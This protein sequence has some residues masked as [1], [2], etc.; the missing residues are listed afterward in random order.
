MSSSIEERIVSMKFNNAQFES[1]VSETMSSLKELNRTIES[2]EKSKGFNGLADS[3]RKVSSELTAMKVI[4]ITALANITNQAVNAG[5]RIVSALTLDPLKSGF[6]EYQEQ[7]DS[8]MVIMSNTG[9][10]LNVVTEALDE[11]NVYA[12]KTVYSFSQMTTAIGKFAA[13]GVNLDNSVA[14]IKGLSNAA[15]LVGANNSQLY[16]AYYNLAQSLQMGY[17]QTIDYNSLSNSTIMNKK[18][19]DIMVETAIEMGKFTKESEIAKEAY[20]DFKGSL[21]KK[22]LTSDIILK[23]LEKYSSVETTIGKEATAAATEVKSFKQLMDTLME[24]IGTGWADT[25]KVLVGD[26]NEAKSLFTGISQALEVFTSSSSKARLDFVKTWKALGGREALIKSFYSGLVSIQSILSPIKTA[27]KDVFPPI[28]AK[29]VANTTNKFLQLVRSMRLTADESKGLYNS[30]TLLLLPAKVLYNVVTTS[31][32][33]IAIL[34]N[35]IVNLGR[36]FL[37]T[38]SS[39]EKIQNGLKAIFGDER[40]ERLLVAFDKIVSKVTYTIGEFKR[41]INELKTEINETGILKKFFDSFTNGADG[42]QNGILD[43]FVEF[44]EWLADL[45]FKLQMPDISSGIID[46]LN[47]VYNTG[48]KTG[49]VLQALGKGFDGLTTAIGKVVT[50]TNLLNV[51]FG[52]LLVKGMYGVTQGIAGIGLGIFGVGKAIKEGAEVV[53]SVG[54]SLKGFAFKEFSEGIKNVGQAIGI[55]A[56]SMLLLS[57][58][59]SGALQ[60]ATLALTAMG[61]VLLLFAGSIGKFAESLKFFK[62]IQVKLIMDEAGNAI[63]KLGVAVL[64]L[65]SSMKMTGS[66]N[67]DEWTNG[68]I[69]VAGALGGLALTAGLLAKHVP[70]LTQGTSAL[71]MMGLAVRLLADSI[72]ILSGIEDPQALENGIVAV[73]VTM[74]A[75]AAIGGVLGRNVKHITSGS[76]AFIALAASVRILVPAL[77][78]LGKI[79]LGQLAQGIV[80]MGLS[81]TI[82]AGV[83]NNVSQVSPKVILTA[84]AMLIMAGAVNTLVPAIKSLGILPFEQIAQGFVGMGLA[85]TILVGAAERISTINIKVL[86][87]AGAMLIMAGA[88]DLLTLAI[89]SFGKMKPEELMQGILGMGV[90]IVILVGALERLGATGPIVLAGAAALLVGAGAMLVMAGAIS[91]FTPAIRALVELPADDIFATLA[92]LSGGLLLLGAVSGIL[93]VLSIAIVPAAIALSSLGVSLMILSPAL[94]A[95]NTVGIDKLA[96]K[97]LLFGSNA[98]IAG[99]GA[100]LLSIGAGGV[101]AFSASLLALSASIGA[102]ELVLQSAVLVRDIFTAGKNLA[103]ELVNG[104]KSGDDSLEKA[105]EYSVSGLEKGVEKKQGVISKLGTSLANLFRGGF[106]SKDGMDIHSPSEVMKKIGEYVVAGLSKGITD[107]QDSVFN[108]AKI[109]GFKTAEETRTAAEQGLDGVAETLITDT[110]IKEALANEQY[111]L[112]SGADLGDSFADGMEMALNKRGRT[113]TIAARNYLSNLSVEEAQEFF[114]A[115]RL[116]EDYFAKID[117]GEDGKKKKETDIDPITPFGGDSSTGKKAKEVSDAFKELRDSIDGATNA[118]EEFNTEEDAY[119]ADKM[120]VNLYSN[121]KGV[122]DWSASLEELSKK[123]FDKAIVEKIAKMGTSGRKYIGGLLEMSDDYISAYNMMYR[124]STGLADETVDKIK[125]LLP[126]ATKKVA[127]ETKKTEELVGHAEDY[128]AEELKESEEVVRKVAKTTA[129]VSDQVEKDSE[130]VQGAITET[131]KVIEETADTS[132]IA[133][134]HHIKYAEAME[135]S[136]ESTD[137]FI[138]V[139]KQMVAD[140]LVANAKMNMAMV[141]LKNNIKETISSSVDLFKAFD[142]SSKV[143]ADEIFANAQSQINAI[144]YYGYALTTLTERGLG[145]GLIDK[146][147]DMGVDGAYQYL[148]AFMTMNSSQITKINKMYEE[149]LTLED[150]EA[151]SIAK[152]YKDAGYISIE[153]FLE[154]ANGN[155]ISKL[156]EQEVS[157]TSNILYTLTDVTFEAAEKVVD[158]NKE[159]KDAVT[160]TSETV[161][162]SADSFEVAADGQKQ[163]SFMMNEGV[164]ANVKFIEVTKQMATDYILANEKMNNAMRDLKSSIKDNITSSI[165]LFKRFDYTAELSAADLLTNIQTQRNAIVYFGDTMAEL[166]ERGLGEGLLDKLR[167]MG[168]DGAF[169]YLA[170][171]RNM[172]DAQIAEVNKTYEQILSLEDSQADKIAQS[173]KNAGIITLE[174]F[175]EGITE[176]SEEMELAMQTMSQLGID[177]LKEILGY[178]DSM[179]SSTFGLNAGKAIDTSIAG[180]IKAESG[181]VTTQSYMLGENSVNSIKTNMNYDTGHGIGINVCL[182]MIG[183]IEEYARQVAEAAASVAAQAAQ[184]ARDAIGVAS[185]AKAFIEIAKYADLGMVEGFEAYSHLVSDASANVADN[186][187]NSFHDVVSKVADYVAS[188]MESVPVIRPIIDMDEIQNGVKKANNVLGGINRGINVTTNFAHNAANSFNTRKAS[189]NDN[190]QIP[191]SQPQAGNTYNFTQNNYSPKALDRIEIYRQTKN[192]FSVMKGMG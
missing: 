35:E 37:V 142:Y 137:N 28:T 76:I 144:R 89:K 182:G 118:F 181:Q 177:K 96:A 79:N 140:Y 5:K 154:G 156:F 24:G 130:K 107:K 174:S 169:Q 98:S 69:G 120:L 113:L 103:S 115:N 126:E 2:T 73:C 10:S 8:T 179:T 49:S 16:S 94:A 21:Q 15:A 109:L 51:A 180:G 64:M 139:T 4:A 100:G 32:G 164:K 108:L 93:G 50:Q 3:V 71:L 38:V 163:Y 67:M 72:K 178:N 74:G 90:S 167:S 151:A 19:R 161:E 152:S 31:I 160:K 40:Y 171:F 44:I 82:L 29:Q 68:M 87:G 149:M 63:L 17:L 81:L 150:S 92:A 168:V 111:L 159:E 183:G 20:N 143:S 85:L 86:A 66:L 88:V 136:T 176:N 61:G 62:A 12:D 119:S 132:I 127:E 190:S 27:I 60:N 121:I 157:R 52:A 125:I 145:Q 39:L 114:R 117:N 47:G 36:K 13:A 46:F 102:L 129:K 155:E 166:A 187:L 91:I 172:D 162:K 153:S 184:A 99:V 78:E 48:E 6:A 70:K 97:L 1:G 106:C 134:E 53:E 135:E 104:W 147:K 122:N 105:G 9:E 83:V 30:I 189:A 65:A 54:L 141:E 148:S 7:M 33:V 14:A 124:V 116:N 59:P 192:Q 43:K 80:S 112:D 138:E 188:D 101:L 55:L 22:W 165:D 42:L 45:D 26:L 58:V 95:L 84:S 146:L 185:P 41:E 110:I 133:A 170:A 123:G 34:A 175:M 77:Q 57:T 56:G 158:A 18:M 23:A 25:F 11:L 191:N 186:S 173:Y 131:G 75:L 128:V